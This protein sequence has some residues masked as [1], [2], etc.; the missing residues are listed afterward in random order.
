MSE[1][2][3]QKK[4]VN[5][6]NFTNPTNPNKDEGKKLENYSANTIKK[7]KNLVPEQQKKKIKILKNRL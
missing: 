3:N 6:T 4:Y 7:A 1:K 2:E 5:P